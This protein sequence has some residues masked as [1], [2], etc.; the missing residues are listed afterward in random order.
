MHRSVLLAAVIYIPVFWALSK[1]VF[2]VIL[3]SVVAGHV[4]HTLLW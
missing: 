2:V 4:I 1:A 3:M